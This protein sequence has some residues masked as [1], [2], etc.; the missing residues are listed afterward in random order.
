MKRILITGKNSYIGTSFEKWMR[1]N[2]PSYEIDTISVH[3]DAWREIDFSSYDVVFHVAGIPESFAGLS[4]G[5]PF[6]WEARPLV[7]NP[8]RHRGRRQ[9][10]TAAKDG[11]HVYRFQFPIE[12]RW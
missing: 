8:R 9:W 6:L 3:G 12:E 10:K 2:H 11:V 5:Q 1:D 7:G 4:L